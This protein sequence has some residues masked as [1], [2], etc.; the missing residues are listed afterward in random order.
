MKKVVHMFQDTNER[1][2]LNDPTYSDSNEIL[3]HRSF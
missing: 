1:I 2:D 3:T